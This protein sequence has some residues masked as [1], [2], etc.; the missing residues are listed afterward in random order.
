MRCFIA[1]DLSSSAKDLL[2]RWVRDNERL[3][4]DVRWCAVEQMH[5]TLHFLG[6]L[7]K[8][9]LYRVSAIVIAAAGEVAPFP[10]TLTGVGA[11]PSLRSPRVLW[12]GL[13]DPA[14]ACAKFVAATRPSISELGIALDDRTFKPHV[15]LARTRGP[16]GTRSLAEFLANQPDSPASC[17]FTVT[18]IIVYE[19]R[20]LPSGAQYRVVHQAPTT[21]KQR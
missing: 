1:V 13:A 3:I 2:I 11:F 6:E 16:I 20:L 9:A 12:A 19:S 15:T 21:G 4:R 18:E 5:V 10:L 14:D 7:D 17:T 8:N